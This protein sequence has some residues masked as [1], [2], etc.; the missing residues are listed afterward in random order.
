M[1][2]YSITLTLKLSLTLTLNLNLTL[3]LDVCNMGV[4]GRRKFNTSQTL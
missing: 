1:L 3:T 2:C 4:M